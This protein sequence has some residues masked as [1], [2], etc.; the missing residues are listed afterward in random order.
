LQ[1]DQLLRERSHPIGVIAGPPKVHPHVATIGP[2]Q[3]RKRLRQRRNV[4]LPHGIVFFARHEQADAPYA[5]ALLRP[6]HDRPSCGG[7]TDPRD[8]IPASHLQSPSS[9]LP[10]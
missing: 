3:V 2:T 1:S 10:P 8:E 7:P 5:V 6:R 4:S 9:K